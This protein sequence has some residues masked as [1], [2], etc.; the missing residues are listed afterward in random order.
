MRRSLFLFAAVAL[1]VAAIAVSPPRGGTQVKA[2]WIALQLPGRNASAS[3]INA[4]GWVVGSSDVKGGGF[5]AALWVHGKLRDL[6]TLGG[7]DSLA[8]DINDRGQI[9]GRS[10]TKAKSW[11]AFLWEKGKMRDLGVL[12]GLH[13]DSEATAI[14]ERGQVVGRTN[15][16]A[17]QSHAWLWESGKMRDLAAL[18]GTSGATDINDYGQAVGWTDDRG[19]FLYQNGR[20]RFLRVESD[21]GG[22][23]INNRGQVV[24]SSQRTGLLWEKGKT[25]T[26]CAH[27]SASNINDRGQVVGSRSVTPYSKDRVSQ[28]FLWESGKLTLLPIP[29]GEY[30]SSGDG[31]NERGQIVGGS[32]A[33]PYLDTGQWAWLWTLKRR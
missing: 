20:A 13:P 10:E 3:A 17:G 19:V 27:C 1:L 33:N 23:S 7:K 14:N 16:P 6:G 4:N 18:V 22:A 9:V 12:P 24:T 5:H 8:N 31:I 21:F 29:A 15:P 32:Y 2:R 26:L 11:H 25:R 28:A 30:G